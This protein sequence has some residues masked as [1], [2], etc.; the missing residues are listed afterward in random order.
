M[1]KI[2]WNV[3]VIYW[4]IKWKSELESATIKEVKPALSPQKNGYIKFGVQ[5]Y[6]YLFVWMELNREAIIT[7]MQR[8]ALLPEDWIYNF[9]VS[10]GIS[11]DV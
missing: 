9:R 4:V 1:L 2:P 5:L 10:V 3:A 6:V 7:D 8:G 11:P